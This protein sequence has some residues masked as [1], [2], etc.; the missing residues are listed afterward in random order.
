MQL[1]ASAVV[2]DCTV[3]SQTRQRGRERITQFHPLVDFINSQVIAEPD[4]HF[5]IAIQ[6]NVQ[7]AQVD[8][9]P[10]IHQFVI[11]RWRAHGIRNQ[12]TLRMS[13]T[14]I[15]VDNYDAT[16]IADGAGLLNSIR[17]LGTTWTTVTSAGINKD[18]VDFAR[19]ASVTRL[20]ADFATFKQQHEDQNTDR[21]RTSAVA[22]GKKRDMQLQKM[23][24]RIAEAGDGESR[25]WKSQQS[26]I[27]NDYKRTM[28][29]LEEGAGVPPVRTTL[30]SGLLQ[31]I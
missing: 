5:W 23:R 8:L 19:R 12:D 20:K 17:S 2:F 26:R 7:E 6:L 1:E 10:G 3:S 18:E 13:L 29:S 30:A 4:R 14:P 28:V 22:A 11:E 15:G 21:Y 9:S 24:E 27:E 16:T 31:L 25:Y